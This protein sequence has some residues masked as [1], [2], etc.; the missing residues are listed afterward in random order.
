METN[1]TFPLLAAT[2]AFIAK[3]KKMLIGAEWTDASSGRAIERH[4]TCRRHSAR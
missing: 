2:Q 3:P 4:G 1:N